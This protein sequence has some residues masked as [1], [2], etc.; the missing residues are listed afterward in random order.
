M[1]GFLLEFLKAPHDRYLHVGR[2][3]EEGW[4]GEKGAGCRR[5]KELL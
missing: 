4:R 5:G 1:A 3:W 2:G